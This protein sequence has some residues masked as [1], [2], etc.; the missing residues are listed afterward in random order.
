VID[1]PRVLRRAERRL[2][3][4]QKALSRK[5][6]GSANRAKARLRVARI[7]AGVADT[8]RDHAHKLSTRIIRDD[9]AVHV[10][11]LC[12]TCP[13]PGWPIRA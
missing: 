9:Q 6:K 4:A 2:K 1:N 5:A 11:D 13:A 7:H 3:K 12:V 8:R 10:E